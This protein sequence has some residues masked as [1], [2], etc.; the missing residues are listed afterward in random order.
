MESNKL[1]ISRSLIV[2]M[3]A[4]VLL[5]FQQCT[6]PIGESEK[7]II[8]GEGKEVVILGLIDH[9]SEPT[10]RVFSEEY[11]DTSTI[12]SKGRF[13]FKFKMTEPSYLSLI[14]HKK[15]IKLFMK[16][17]DTLKVGFNPK[18]LPTSLIFDGKGAKTN[19]Y[20]KSKYRLML[21]MTIP[22]EHLYEYSPSAFKA[23]VDSFYVVQ[24]INLDMHL[25]L[26]KDVPDFFIKQEQASIWYERATKMYEYLLLNEETKNIQKDFYAFE[27]KTSPDKDSLINVYEYR[28]YL[29]AWINYLGQKQLKND[30]IRN[31]SS[32]ELALAKMQLTVKFLKSSQVKNYLLSSILSEYISYYGYKNAK[33]LFALYDYQ[34]TDTVMKEKLITPYQQYIQLSQLSKAPS[35]SFYNN[36][37]EVLSLDDFVGS[38]L[39]VDVWATWC[40]PCRKQTPHFEQMAN[41]NKDKNITFISLSIDKTKTD[42][43]EFLLKK[44]LAEHQY[45]IKDIEAFLDGYQIKTIPHFLIIN[46]KGQISNADA[47]RPTDKNHDWLNKI[48]N[49]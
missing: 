34:C 9:A 5:M 45:L 32:S 49:K 25:E 28:S 12:D 27:K 46:D 13:K 16:P 19:V 4:S 11:K 24:K 47:P 7:N 38:Y 15:A 36:M 17:G 3:W 48:P 37:G 31:F 41:E 6:P 33:D 20:L 14:T 2:L 42:W 43:N 22:S 10:I 8:K 44:D 35:V 18:D 39:Y 23:H 26:M 40:M 30:G 1:S 21:E 29:K